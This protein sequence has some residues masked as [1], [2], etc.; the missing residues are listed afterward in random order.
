MMDLDSRNRQRATSA[1]SKSAVSVIIPTLASAE[2]ADLLARAIRSALTDQGGAIVPIVVVNG[3]RHAPEV[4]AALK[5]RGDI[6]YH[7]REQGNAAAA[8]LAGRKMVDTEFFA[9]LDDDDEFLPMACATRLHYLRS[10]PT[11]DVVITNGFRRHGDIEV[12]DYPAFASFSEDPLGHLMET[13]WL[14]PAGGLYRT[15]TVTPDIFD[16]P[17][18]MEWTYLAMTLAMHRKLCF[19]DVPTYRMHRDTPG[20]L[21]AALHWQRAAPETLRRMLALDPPPR[22]RRRLRQKY[23]TALHALTSIAWDEGDWRGA[24]RA[25]AASLGS[26]YGLRYLPFTRKLLGFDRAPG[27]RPPL[28]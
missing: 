20:S 23:V 5:S 10:D 28:T 17:H 18:S 25:H 15:E 26:I 16:A 27:T 4:L 7:Y 3:N 14:Q 1:T 9:T 24:W 21:S 22:I 19:V 8:R 12:L 2:R 13:C 6:R 11:V